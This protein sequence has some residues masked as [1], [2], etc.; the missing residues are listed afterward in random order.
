MKKKKTNF[1]E[2][3]KS[4]IR[5]I[6]I[7][8]LSLI[9]LV[10]GAFTIGFIESALI[11]ALID[12]ILYIILKPKEKRKKTS[13]KEKL[14]TFLIICFGCAII[15]LLLFIA[16]LIY[17]VVTSEDFDPSLL[18]NK[19]A[20]ILYDKDG[21]EIVK[22]GSS[23]GIRENVSYDNV[24]QSLIDAIVATEDSRFFQHNGVD[25]PRF[26]KAS[27]SQLLGK[28]GGGASTLTMQVS[29]NIYTSTE[30]QGI[31]GIIRKFNDIYISVFKIETHY[32]KEDILEFYMNYNNLG[33][34][35][36]GVQQASQTYFNKDASDLNVSEAAM[37]AGLFQAPSAYN[38]F[39]YPEACEQRRLTVLS[40]MLRH[41]YITKE[42][43]EIAKELTVD[44]IVVG[45]S[46]SSSEYQ[47]FIDTVIKEVQQRTGNDPYSVPMKIYTTMD[48]SMQDNMNSVF[49]GES[50]TWVN[51]SVQ[52][53]SVVLDVN[54]GGIAAI[55]GGRN[56]VAMGT[57]FATDIQRQIGSTAKPL[58]DYGPY[59]EYNNGSTYSI[60]SDEPYAYSDG[61]ALKNWDNDY[62]TSDIKANTLWNSLKESRNIPAVK[63]FQ[64][65]KNS[66]IKTFV[67]NL[68]LSPEID[69]SG[70]IHESHALGGYTG[71]SP[72][73]MAAAYAAFSNGGY[74]NEPHS[75]TKIEYTETGEEYLVKPTKTKVMSDSTAYMITKI[76]EDTA[77][78]AINRSVN[79]VNYCGKTGTTNLTNEVI[80][81]YG[82]PSNAIR[83]RWIASYNDSYAITLW[84][85][86]EY[87]NKDN[88]LTMSQY[89]HKDL[90]QAIAKGVYTKNSTW[91]MPSSVVTA[92][93]ETELPTA[94]LASEYTPAANKTTAYFKK[95][96]EPTETSTR[97]SQLE[98]VKNLKYE[99]GIISWDAIKTPD[100]ID[101][102][103]ITSL[104]DK[105]FT[106]EDT[107]QEEIAKR[108]AYNNSNIGSIVYEIYSKDSSGNLSLITTT[109]DT[110]Y[111]YYGNGNIVVKT[112]Y[113][114]FK[115]NRSSGSE[116]IV[117]SSIITSELSGS[118]TIN[119]NVGDT[120]TEPDKPVIVLEN[121]NVDVTDK[122]TITYTIT[123][124]SDNTVYDKMYYIS[125]KVAD[126][127]TIKYK[128]TYGNY[129]NTLTKIIN[130]KEKTTN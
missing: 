114:I 128:I 98:N 115:D 4:N 31:K 69:S 52:A 57:N 81:Q 99:N 12:T 15:L 88:V 36:K 6:L 117:E 109:S 42:E 83:D 11:I 67:T 113:S 25:L 121:G 63:A 97:Y 8:T 68:G 75:F 45:K 105:L 112:A 123:K 106:D 110:K 72:L 48:R 120:Y 23:D 5:P 87:L 2:L 18:Y 44:K 65:V 53:G 33:A 86:Y 85:G 74:Y 95:G 73:S 118:S 124:S 78:S 14:K 38:P 84:Y 60:F 56:Y 9:L 103:Y 21:E 59:M 129:T 70:I 66:N 3:F 32:T 125:T 104:F 37:I 47:V 35:S 27:I 50:Y 111:Q 126:T 92:T 127:Y 7:A 58:Y 61:T 39:V 130:V 77:G 17:I 90:F 46:T 19:E 76:L 71:E 94:M 80:K 40:L 29:K 28:G 116:I 64:S 82:Y 16:F 93:V 91:E 10:A 13:F 119:L 43:Y 108:I 34:Y 24:S 102:D 107:K 54:D 51:D 100:F 79:G 49:N 22:L 20:S 122:A 96:T 26:I 41:G 101:T 55:G 30:D 89:N 62:G 1:V